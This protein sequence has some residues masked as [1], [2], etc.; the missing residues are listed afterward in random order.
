MKQF[1]YLLLI[2]AFC[3]TSCARR[4]SITGGLKDTIPPTILGSDPKNFSTEFKGKNIKITFDEF[5]KLKDVNKQLIVSPP[6]KVAPSITPTTASKTIN[7]KIFDTLQPNTTYSFNF[8][9]S[10]ADN[11]EGNP[12]PLFKYVFSTGTYID[13]LMLS[14]KIKDALS[15]TPDN[16]VSVMLYEMD[17]NYTDSI[18]YKQPPRYITNTLDSLKVFK[19]DFLKAGKYQLIALK[20]ANGNNKFDPKTDKIAFQ[21]DPITIPNDTIFELEL[22]KEKLPFKAIRPLQASGNKILMGYEGSAKNTK[23]VLKNGDEIVP[24]IV[25]KFAEKD[26]L[27]IWYSKVKTDSLQFAITNGDYQKEFTVKMRSQKNDSLNFKSVFSSSIPMSKTFSIVAT[28]PIVKID[29]T[30]IYVTNKDSVAVPFSTEYDN[31]NM[32]LKIL[33]KKEPLEKYRITLLPGALTDFYEQA[34]DT[35][36]Y[37]V[38]TKAASEYGNLRVILENVKSFPILVELLNSKGELQE[39]KY[40]ESAST[41]DFESLEPMLYTLRVIYDENK[42]GEWDPGNFLQ[43]KQSE[44]V[45]YFPKQIELRANWEVDQP[46]IL[47]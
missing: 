25:T 1:L 37:R 12:Y 14:G 35:L 6:M 27:E 39:S 7:I 19:L 13:S 22:F 21:K 20:D 32:N 15:K 31:Y 2:V 29:S 40:S 46:F 43:R 30:L 17:D 24:S 36:K 23:V 16:F 28:R 10:I 38:S 34:N 4:G 44:Q 18:V 42:N 9:R 8:G 5:V 3:S 47:N 33:F 45:I 26:S 41:I 11:N